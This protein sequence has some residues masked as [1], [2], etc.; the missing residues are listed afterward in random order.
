MRETDFAILHA[1][2]PLGLKPPAPG[3]V[4]GVRKAPT[5]LRELGLH[6][7]LGA[8]FVGTV[9][10]PPYGYG[11]ARPA[12]V[13]NAAGV[14]AYGRLLS[15]AL[16]PLLKGY[17]FPLVLGGDCSIALGVADALSKSG[18]RFGLLYLDAHSDCQTPDTSHTGGIAGMPLAMITGSVPSALAP[19]EPPRVTLPSSDVVLI[20]VRDLFDV[21]ASAGGSRVRNTG[22]RVRDLDEVRRAGAAAAADVALSDLSDVDALW[23]HLDADVMDSAIMPA[24]DSPDPGGLTG[25]ELTELLG[26]LL[27]SPKTLGMH[28]TIYDPERDPDRSAGRLLV[29][30]LTSALTSARAS[31]TGAH[32]VTSVDR[33]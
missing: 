14:A 21:E 25:T 1:P 28:V 17:A 15:T 20:G 23:V 33:R 13:R 8:R 24:V 11:R 2:S 22:V 4:P 26:T 12:G 5:A 31:R 30:V 29:D 27:S 7:R 19:G 18:H 16:A 32:D 9:E 10:A 3:Q 6:A